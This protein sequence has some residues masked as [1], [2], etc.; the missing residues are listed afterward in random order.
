[1]GMAGLYIAWLETARMPDRKLSFDTDFAIPFLVALA[2]AVVIFIQTEGFTTKAKPLVSWPKVRRR[3][4]I[5][6]K[7]FDKDGNE[8]HDNNKT[9]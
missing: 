1:M 7:Y 9:D 6:H 4:K 5:I 3:K 8:I 2:L